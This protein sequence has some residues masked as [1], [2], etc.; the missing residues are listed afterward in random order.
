MDSRS[1][2]AQSLENQHR[3]L[4]KKIATEMK[5][6]APDSMHLSQLK[7]QKLAIKEELEGIVA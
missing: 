7:K 4:D 1:A 3:D 2:H 5:R 6:R